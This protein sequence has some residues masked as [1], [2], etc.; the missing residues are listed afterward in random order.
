V[1][2]IGGTGFIGVPLVHQLVNGGH[3]VTVFHQGKTAGKLPSSV[4]RIEGNRQQLEDHRG[5]FRWCAPEV[6][7]DMIAFTEQ[8]A[9]RFVSVFRGLAQRMVVVSSADVYKAYGMFIGLEEGPIAETPLEEGAALRTVR[10]P[11]RTQAEG[12]EDFRYWY[13]KIPVE[14]IILGEP[15]LPGTILRLPMV[16][17][18]GDPF[19][20]LGAYVKRMVSGR[21]AIL[22]DE[23]MA[24]WKCP[25]GEVENVAAAIAVAAVHPSAAGQV[26]NIA[27]PVAHT[28]A[29][30]VESIGQV[31]GWRGCVVQVP[32]GRIPAPYRWEHL[33]HTDSGR[34]R[35]EL[36]YAEL[37]KPEEALFRTIVWERD[38][39]AHQRTGIGLLDETTE[40][41]M[42]DELGIR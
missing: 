24:R 8:D 12:P 9:K 20:R 11:Y 6:V 29:D 36:D 33:V 3:E 30:W 22:L 38:H 39:P 4:T 32:K 42:L 16:H 19:H 10:F 14:Q 13:D 1:L 18:P 35:R 5:E 37:V 31:L 21:S 28:E 2:I 25:R 41:I 26:Y 34:I 27:E 15:D 23:V 17:G 40:D 7:V